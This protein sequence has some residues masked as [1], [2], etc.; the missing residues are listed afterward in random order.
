MPY[1]TCKKNEIVKSPTVS[2]KVY[3]TGTY[4][5]GYM[6][7]K[8]CSRCSVE[9][10]VTEFYH[11]RGRPANPCKGCRKATRAP[12]DYKRERESEAK[13][14]SDAAYEER[15]RERRNAQRREN[16]RKYYLKNRK[17]VI[18]KVREAQDK[19]RAEMLKGA[20]EKCG[21]DLENLRRGRTCVPCSEKE[22][23]ALKKKRAQSRERSKRYYAKKREERIAA[24]KKAKAEAKEAK[25]RKKE[26][27]IK[28]A[29]EARAEALAK[30]MAET[31]VRAKKRDRE[32][33]RSP[34]YLAGRR[35]YNNRRY[36]ENH[37]V[38]IRTS[39]SVFLWKQLK[40]RGTG[41]KGHS[42]WD[43]L[44]YTIEEL[45]AHLESRF[46]V[47]MT[48]ENQGEWHIDHIRPQSQY[49]FKLEEHPEV[50]ADPSITSWDAIENPM[51]HPDVARCNALSNLRPLWAKE[52]VRRGDRASDN[53]ILLEMLQNL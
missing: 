8:T 22:K 30:Q 33:R 1:R 37:A 6:E 46:E 28:A 47:G 18:A 9:L 7:T 31:K 11:A 17:Q 14:A 39:M 35:K 42:S 52:N 27:D 13:R 21:G 36:A 51:L 34:E 41:K 5:G 3:K 12:R 38:R 2:D 24:E 10:P 20:C 16:A 43:Y 26:A 53:E 19:K 45:A 29:K 49:K 48:W 50:I 23:A 4:V 25:R 40:Q 32:R 15:H 44:P